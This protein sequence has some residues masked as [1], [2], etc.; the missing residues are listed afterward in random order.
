MQRINHSELPKYLQVTERLRHEIKAGQWKPGDRLPGYGEAQARYATTKNTLEKAHRQLEKD[1]L[2]RRVNGLG[3]FVA[4]P[5]KRPLTGMIGVVHVPTPPRG[6]HT[7]EGQNS[8]QAHLMQGIKDEAHH[9]GME[10]LLLNSRPSAGWERVDGVLGHGDAAR[11]IRAMGL[12][13]PAVSMMHVVEGGPSVVANDRAGARLATEHLLSLGHRRIAYLLDLSPGNPLS[14]ERLAGYQNALRAARIKPKRE[15]IGVLENWG[16]MLLRGHNSMSR[17][18][19]NGWHETGC[20]A[21]LVQNDRAAIGAMETLREA[22]LKV[23]RDIS[24]VG[25]DSTDECE[26]V[27][28]ALT[29]VHVPLEDIGAR[30]ANMLLRLIQEETVETEPMMLPVELQVRESTAAPAKT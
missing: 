7:R 11:Y 24:V 16:T 29:S 27:R 17:W 19:E 28:P 9:A 23:P 10:V 18:L 14:K 15:W 13:I 4:E 26:I 8:Y 20:T 6:Q 12:D 21:L 22:G 30:A 25:F 5:R 3:V 2:I 1:G